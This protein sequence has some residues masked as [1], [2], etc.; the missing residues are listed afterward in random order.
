MNKRR[1]RTVRIVETILK[2]VYPKGLTLRQITGEMIERGYK[3][4]PSPNSLAN[5]LGKRPQFVAHY[6]IATNSNQFVTFYACTLHAMRRQAPFI[7][8]AGNVNDEWS[9]PVH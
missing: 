1:G 2:D 4:T 3:F 8:S 6:D 5:I 9:L 7:P